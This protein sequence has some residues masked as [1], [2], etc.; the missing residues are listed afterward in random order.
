MFNL[1]ALYNEGDVMMWMG[2]DF[3]IIRCD[4]EAYWFF[5]MGY[6]N[7]LMVWNLLSYWIDNDITG[8][9]Y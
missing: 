2:T 3:T 4:A 9:F 7:F 8:T 6:W 5:S 1:Y